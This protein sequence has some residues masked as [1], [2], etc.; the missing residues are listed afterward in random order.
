MKSSNN[1]RVSKILAR[2]KE[3]AKKGLTK[4]K[5]LVKKGVE[6]SKQLSKDD[7]LVTDKDK[8]HHRREQELEVVVDAAEYHLHPNPFHYAVYQK[9]GTTNYTK[10]WKVVGIDMFG[11]K[12]ETLVT[13][14]RMSNQDDVKNAIKDAGYQ[15]SYSVLNAKDFRCAQNRE[16]L[17]IVGTIN[18]K[19]N[20]FYF[21][22]FSLE[23]ISV[24]EVIDDLIEKSIIRYYFLNLGIFIIFYLILKKKYD[25]QD[26]HL[27]I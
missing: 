5:E 21:P 4:S 15:I 17:F 8:K 1:S 24:K 19:E 3:L 11:K 27:Q 13:L 12:F 10:K 6:K 2:S 22:D 25:F 9:G 26:F 23:K 20:N 14:G 7:K 16:R 18:E